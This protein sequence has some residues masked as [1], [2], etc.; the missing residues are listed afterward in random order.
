MGNPQSSH[1]ALEPL[2]FQGL[3]SGLQV[4]VWLAREG[5]REGELGQGESEE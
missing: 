3:S 4:A 1:M 5:G 2:G